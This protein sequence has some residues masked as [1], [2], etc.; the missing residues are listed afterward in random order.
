MPAMLWACCGTS[1]CH[2]ISLSLRLL[3]VT[4]LSNALLQIWCENQRRESRD[5]PGSQEGFHSWELLQA[6]FFLELSTRTVL[7]QQ[8]WLLL[9]SYSKW[10][11]PSH[12]TPPL[13]S[14]P[15]PSLGRGLGS[16][17][18][19][20]TYPW[21]SYSKQPTK[22]FFAI[23]PDPPTTPLSRVL[24]PTLQRHHDLKSI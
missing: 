22:E 21:W 24:V 4:R 1:A 18:G 5:T 15:P 12:V 11:P 3:M 17:E 16:G 8:V 9:P 23:W 6:W 13:W 14:E 20:Y 2:S 19:S 10:R 7:F